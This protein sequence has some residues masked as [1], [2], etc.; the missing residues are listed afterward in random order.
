MFDDDGVL[1]IWLGPGNALPGRPNEAI[2]PMFGRAM[3]PLDI[4]K[5][6]ADVVP[7]GSGF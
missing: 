2:G 7:G 5:R 3:A 6:S 1:D 4:A